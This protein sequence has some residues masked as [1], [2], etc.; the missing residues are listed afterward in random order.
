MS[1]I[2]GE[3]ME[4]DDIIEKSSSAWGSTVCIVAKADGSPRFC[5]DYSNTSNKF[6]VR[7]TRSMPDIESHINT[8]GGAKFIIVCDVQ[9]AYW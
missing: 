8:I 4:S 9:K 6:L 5:V 2:C 7:E 1:D 3:S